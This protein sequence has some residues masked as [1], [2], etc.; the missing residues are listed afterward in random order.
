MSPTFHLEPI[1]EDDPTSAYRAV[2]HP[3][4][5]INRTDF[6]KALLEQGLPADVETVLALFDVEQ[7]AIASLLWEGWDVA[8][9]DDIK[10]ETPCPDLSLSGLLGGTVNGRAV[11]GGEQVIARMIEFGAPHTPSQI[12]AFFEA[13]FEAT[14]HL[15][16]EGYSIEH[17]TTWMEPAIAG[18]FD[19]PHDDFDPK[20]HII[21]IASEEGSDLADWLK[22][23]QAMQ[24]RQLEGPPRPLLD[25]YDDVNTRQS[26]G[27]V[28]PGHMIRLRGYWLRFQDFDPRQGVFLS[29]E[30]GT[31]RKV[32]GVLFNGLCEGGF[33]LPRDLPLGSYWL[34]LRA[35]I[36]PRDG[37]QRAAWPHPIRVVADADGR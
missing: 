8:L 33:A 24:Q 26:Q 17:P 4:G 3:V 19:S 22:G 11:A 27:P 34:E 16:G 36:V 28:S 7:A 29:A 6:A 37:L 20:R 10:T 12:E 14:I 31:T 25:G 32:R 13:Q 5:H 21:E 18:P 15:I 23:Y 35:V 1:D 9:P 30:D 2:V